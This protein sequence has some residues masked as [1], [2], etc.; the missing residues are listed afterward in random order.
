MAWLKVYKNVFDEIHNRV[1][2]LYKE[3]LNSI[4][5][6]EELE[7]SPF[8][9]YELD[10]GESALCAAVGEKVSPTYFIVAKVRE[11]FRKNGVDQ[12]IANL[13]TTSIS[14]FLK[15]IGYTHLTFEMRFE[16][17]LKDLQQQKTLPKSE[18][19]EQRRYLYETLG[20]PNLKKSKIFSDNDRRKM[21]FRFHESL[22]RF[23]FHGYKTSKDGRHSRTE[24]MLVKLIMSFKAIRKNLDLGVEIEN[25]IDTIA[26]GIHDDFVGE[27]YFD[28]STNNVMVLNLRTKNSDSRQ[29]NLKISIPSEGILF[30]GQYSNYDEEGR[31]YSGSF[32]IEQVFGEYREKPTVYEFPETYSNIDVINE[33][34]PI[35]RFFSDEKSN[36]RRTP[37]TI[38]NP[39]NFKRWVNDNL[40]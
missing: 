1:Y 15:Y 18:I 37:R 34:F 39:E 31:I 5:V 13:A 14:P 36:Y 11:K 3:Y 10:S 33:I 23:Y 28:L 8:W 7:D 38:S 21:V 22:W 17:F 35:V 24:W 9:K 26:S 27:S 30:L 12:Q 32:L 4:G 19:L 20:K 29:L 2:R 16:E 25:T 40:L 6:Y